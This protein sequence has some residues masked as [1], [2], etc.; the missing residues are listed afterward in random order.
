M[1]VGSKSPRY[2]FKKHKSNH[3]V[4]LTE[5]AYI[6]RNIM[7]FSTN[8]MENAVH[9]GKQRSMHHIF[10]VTKSE[11]VTF[12]LICCLHIPSLSHAR[13]DRGNGPSHGCNLRPAN[14][15]KIG[16]LLPAFSFTALKSSF[17]TE[18]FSVLL[19]VFCQRLLMLHE[20][21]WEYESS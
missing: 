19:C 17:H 2:L 1:M 3:N 16:T 4:F 13:Y 5:A 14:A 15:L 11:P 12:T 20:Q 21:I 8:S 18:K 9:N 10:H 7:L 6:V